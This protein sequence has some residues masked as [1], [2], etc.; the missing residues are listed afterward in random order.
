[1]NPLCKLCGTGTTRF[2][3]RKLGHFHHCSHCEFIFKDETHILDE[4]SEFESYQRHNNS[5]DDPR[6]VDFFYRFL[7]D[8]V[9]PYAGKGKQGF[10]F[11]SGPSPVLAQI[12]ER[13]H[14]YEMDI[15]DIFYSPEKV[16]EEKKYDLITCTEVAEHL[17]D[18]IHHFRLFTELMT[19]GSILSVMTLFHDNNEDNFLNW[20]YMRDRTHISFYTPVTMEYIADQVG[21]EVIH[22]NDVRY[23]TFRLK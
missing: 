14:G 18:P 9:F 22:T 15:F 12:L 20:H 21:L 1:M 7:E 8:A 3:H 17:R 6:Y 2:I 4:Q 10:D 5:I 11:G 13:H 16:Y 23:I 19:P